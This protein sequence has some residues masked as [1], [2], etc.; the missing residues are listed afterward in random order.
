LHLDNE[1]AIRRQNDAVAIEFK[2][3]P[4]SVVILQFE[5]A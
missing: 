4:A 1:I 2:N 3:L 5:W